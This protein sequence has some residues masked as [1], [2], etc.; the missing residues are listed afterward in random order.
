MANAELV[1]Y[2]KQWFEIEAHLNEEHDKEVDDELWARQ[3]DLESKI[4][5]TPADDASGV[6]LKTLP[7]MDYL[8]DKHHPANLLASICEDSRRIAENAWRAGIN[9]DP[10][11][12]ELVR[13]G[14]LNLAQQENL[15][16]DNQA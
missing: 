2:V 14:Q 7:A 8:H 9:P 10:S 16:S 11:V 3:T 5:D 13:N 4:A 6:Y 15:R 1:D 12:A